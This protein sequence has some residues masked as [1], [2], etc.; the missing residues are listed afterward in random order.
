[1]LLRQT[2]FGVHQGF[3]H[4]VINNLLVFRH[5]AER[6]AG[7]RRIPQ[8]VY[9]ITIEECRLNWGLEKLSGKRDG[10]SKLNVLLKHEFDGFMFAER[11]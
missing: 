9:H 10:I 3:I 8:V 11:Y 6:V 7:P 1:M 5:E 4:N 2:C